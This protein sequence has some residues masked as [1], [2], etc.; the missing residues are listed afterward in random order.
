MPIQFT[1]KPV[2][3]L[4]KTSIVAF[5]HSTLFQPNKQTTLRF[6]LIDH[7]Y[8]SFHPQLMIIPTWA[9]PQAGFK[10]MN[11]CHYHHPFRIRTSTRL[12]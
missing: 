5:L 6:A 11:I 2:A 4:T 1:K 7:S 8:M 9:A 3:T 10:S 12:T